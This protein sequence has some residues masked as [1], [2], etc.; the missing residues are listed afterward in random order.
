MNSQNTSTVTKTELKL[1]PEHYL[2]VD[3]LNRKFGEYALEVVILKSRIAKLKCES[4][5]DSDL[6]YV[7]IISDNLFKLELKP[8]AVR[9]RILKRVRLLIEELEGLRAEI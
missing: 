6:E 3:E 5:S 1:E 4:E 8:K 7:G 9:N 2:T